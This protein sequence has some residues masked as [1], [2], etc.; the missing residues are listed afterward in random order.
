MSITLPAFGS[1]VPQ[2]QRVTTSGQPANYG[3]KANLPW[4]NLGR[5]QYIGLPIVTKSVSAQNQWTTPSYFQAYRNGG[6]VPGVVALSISG[7][8]TGKV[9][10][11]KSYDD[12]ATW[13]DVKTWTAPAEETFENAVAA[14]KW[15]LGVKTGEFTS[16]PI[17]LRMSQA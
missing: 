5:A 14:V 7:T 4:T 8:F 15:Q 2:T 6:G 11:Q 17:T 10:L 9:T 1:H 3:G 12:G 13:L 16:G